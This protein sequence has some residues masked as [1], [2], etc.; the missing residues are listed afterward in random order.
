MQLPMILPTSHV[1]QMVCIVSAY[2]LLVR[3]G[4]LESVSPA[5]NT[6]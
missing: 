1:E 5:S 4:C 2:H 6:L 3:E